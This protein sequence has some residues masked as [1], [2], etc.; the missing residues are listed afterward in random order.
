[1]S[2]QSISQFLSTVSTDSAL[3]VARDNDELAE[4]ELKAVVGG[5]GFPGGISPIAKPPK[6]P[7]MGPRPGG[8]AAPTLDLNLESALED[9]NHLPY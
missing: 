9:L 4:D 7:K 1:M 2:T 8:E 5:A 3:H 6:P